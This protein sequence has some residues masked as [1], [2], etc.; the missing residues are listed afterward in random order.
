M[1][2]RLARHFNAIQLTGGIRFAFT[3]FP[4]LE[5]LGDIDFNYND[6]VQW[7]LDPHSGTCQELSIPFSM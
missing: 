5:H 4:P 6:V 3:A 2:L 7:T 1:V